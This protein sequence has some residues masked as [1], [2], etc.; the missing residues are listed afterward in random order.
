MNPSPT[1]TFSEV[2]TDTDQL[3]GLYRSP[4]QGA[5]DKVIH[6]IDAGCRDLIALS[7][8][9]MVGT[10]GADGHL[11]VSPRGGPAGFVSVLDD[12][13]LAIPDLSGNNRLDSLRNIVESGQIALLFTVPGLDETL[14]V[15]GAACITTADDVLDGFT[16]ELKRPKAAIG[17]EVREAFIHCAKA[18][19]RGGVWEPETWPDENSCPSVGQILVDHIG[20]E[21][22]TGDELS[23]GLETGY[24]HDLAHER[25]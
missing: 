15:N 19:R 7:T 4:G 16:A 5:R 11:D 24:Q 6:Q 10:A 21:G 18:F 25:A 1:T 8:L 2:L 22:I 17:V 23:A 12:H 9:V 13:R 20:L 14:R 3:E